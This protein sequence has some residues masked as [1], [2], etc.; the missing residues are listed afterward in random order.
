[1]TAPM[2][3]YSAEAVH[4]RAQIVETRLAALDLPAGAARNA[5]R[6]RISEEVEAEEAASAKAIADR[7]EATEERARLL[8]IWRAGRDRD[9]GVQALRM[10]LTAPVTARA[11]EALLPGLPRDAE[12]DPA[13][14]VMPGAAAFGTDAARAERERIRRIL[15]APEAKGRMNA[16]AALA[17]EGDGDL[18]AAMVAPLLAG[19]PVE[20]PKLSGAEI[21]AA[22]AAGFAEFGP[23]DAPM[24]SKGETVRQGWRKAA[25][26][27]N[28]SIGAGPS[29]PEGGPVVLDL[30]GPGDPAFGTRADLDKA[31]AAAR[32]GRGRS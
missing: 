27:A 5:A 12:A 2:L 24:Q 18:T 7:A 28:A 29:V 22:R 1:M 26:Q 6:K 14:L 15:T 31:L 10:A 17:L 20:G 32:A 19:M 13:S 25:A 11:V 4:R 30:A 23:S 8:A 16:A 3:D 21:L 9:R